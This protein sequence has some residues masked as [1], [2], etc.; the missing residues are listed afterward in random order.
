M[1]PQDVVVLL[2]FIS[3]DEKAS[4]Q[5]S[6]LSQS[7]FISVSEISESLNRSKQ[8][9]LLDYQKKNI[10]RQNLMEFLVHGVKY[11]FPQRLGS[12]VR[13]MPTAHSHPFIEKYISSE[14]AY[15]WPDPQGDRIGLELVPFY[16]KQVKA[17]REDDK[18]YKLLALVDVIR[19]GKIREINIAVAELKKVLLNES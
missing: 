2:K 3:T 18:L 1:R 5:L 16:E 7:L 4:L 14:I 10:M 19:V 8:A 17:A 12:M 6:R 13:G 11:V 9:N 15:V